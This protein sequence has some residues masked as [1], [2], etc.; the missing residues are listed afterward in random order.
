[1][2]GQ[3]V[4]L[5]L[6]ITHT[7]S[8]SFTVNLSSKA[9]RS[10]RGQLLTLF[11]FIDG[12]NSSLTFHSM[13]LMN[14]PG[15]LYL[16]SLGV[17]RPK[18]G[19]YGDECLNFYKRSL[20]NVSL[21]RLSGSIH[22]GSFTGYFPAALVFA[23]QYT[24][25]DTAKE[26]VDQPIKMRV[27]LLNS[28]GEALSGTLLGLREHFIGLLFL[29]VITIAL[30]LYLIRVSSCCPS[31][32]TMLLTSLH[33]LGVCGLWQRFSLSLRSWSAIAGQSNRWSN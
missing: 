11:T 21:S 16:F 19:V 15:Y 13:Q 24:C 9:A 33:A 5:M 8:L 1:M 22:L 20:T 27:T 3:A 29:Y 30:A 12:R 10:Y 23:D 18:L 7:Q 31:Q 32:S 17:Q 6:L 4:C 28:H 2:I 14:N 26:N 25:L